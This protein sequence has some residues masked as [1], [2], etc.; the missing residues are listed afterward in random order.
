L[1]RA[2][3]YIFIGNVILSS[4][5]ISIIV[6]GLSAH[7]IQ[8]LKI[9]NIAKEVD[10]APLKYRTRIINE[11]TTAHFNHLLEYEMWGPVFKN[12]DTNYKFNSFLFIFLKFFAA[13]FP[14]QNKSVRK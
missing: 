14:F 4:S 11:E 2:T 6:N 1:N 10:L 9:S 8:I 7:D 3:D 13:S 12:R 5:C